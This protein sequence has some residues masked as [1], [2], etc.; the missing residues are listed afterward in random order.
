MSLCRRAGQQRA[1]AKLV[2]RMSEYRQQRAPCYGRYVAMEVSVSH[3]FT[4]LTRAGESA[5]IPLRNL[6]ADVPR[7][8][9]GRRV[10][11][12]EGRHVI[13]KLVV[14]PVHHRVDQLLHLHEIHQQSGRI[15]PLARQRHLHSVIVGRARSRTCHDSCARAC[16]AAKVSSTETSNIEKT[17]PHSSIWV[18]KP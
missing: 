8:I 5:G 17:S 12:V 14:H 2:V 15:Q 13:E 7:H 11:G 9:L 1:H 16:P 6:F 4:S 18:V 3:N 10:Q